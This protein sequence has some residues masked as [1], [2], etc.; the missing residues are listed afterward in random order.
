MSTVP[1]TTST[2]W[3]ERALVIIAVIIERDLVGII[4]FAIVIIIIILIIAMMI[5]HHC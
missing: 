5:G 2:V 4:I 1:S 3:K